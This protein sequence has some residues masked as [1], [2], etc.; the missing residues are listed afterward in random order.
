MT[1]PPVVPGL[2]VDADLTNKTE[3]TK[4]GDEDPTHGLS[5]KIPGLQVS[6]GNSPMNLDTKNKDASDPNNQFIKYTGQGTVRIMGPDEW[7]AANVDS[8]DYCEWN[9]LNRMM[10][11]RSSF[12]DAQLQYLL[13][14]DDRFE[15]VT[16]EPESDDK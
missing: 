9:Y 4:K 3:D 10:I 15:L 12:T 8:N 7:K 6:E 1:Q 5:E 16:V 2:K 13:R 11:P 14:I